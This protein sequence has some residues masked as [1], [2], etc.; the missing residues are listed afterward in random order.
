MK[1]LKKM[2][3]EFIGNI[4][5][6]LGGEVDPELQALLHAN[7]FNFSTSRPAIIH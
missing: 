7:I 5:L 4:Q 3:A 6:A 1:L 2:I